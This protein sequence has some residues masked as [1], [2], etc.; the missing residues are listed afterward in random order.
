M[1]KNTAIIFLN[2]LISPIIAVVLVI[3]VARY[4]S[5]EDMGKYS[6]IRS[7]FSIFMVI[8]SFGL[9]RPLIREMANNQN[10]AGVYFFNSALLGLVSSIAMVGVASAIVLIADYPRDV[11]I[12]VTII[13]FSLLATT[14]DDYCQAVFAAFEK[15]GRNTVIILVASLLRTA[16]AILV[17]VQGHGLFLLIAVILGVDF[18]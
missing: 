15:F 1:T 17:L 13:S 18:I 11:R 5:V 4:L 10:R 8:A 2:R 16:A 14:L 12:G 3:Y 7:Y 9:Q 6:F